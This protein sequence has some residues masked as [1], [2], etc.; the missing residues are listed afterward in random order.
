MK[1]ISWEDISVS[2]MDYLLI[3][4]AGYLDGDKK[5]VILLDDYVWK[6]N[7]KNGKEK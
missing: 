2:D 5:S 3:D 4:H 1:E 6:L 7:M